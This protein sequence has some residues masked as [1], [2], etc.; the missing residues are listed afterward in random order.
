MVEIIHKS[1]GKPL[2]LRVARGSAILNLT[3]VPEAGVVEGKSV[4]LIGIRPKILPP[5]YVHYSPVGAIVKGSQ[6]FY[7][8]MELMLKSIFSRDVAKNAGGIISIGAQIHQDS[9]D[10]LR[11]LLPTAALLSL[12]LGIIN[13]FP[14]PILDGGHLLLLGWEGIR[15]RK[16]TTKEVLTAQML[17]FSI[18]AVLF[19]LVTCKDFIQVILPKI[20]KHG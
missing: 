3:I 12:N 4:G 15:R 5:K 9:N 19:V 7:T 6:I 20:M 11:S 2:A 14:I 17:G 16:L 13:L 8:M 18:I 1:A 10:G